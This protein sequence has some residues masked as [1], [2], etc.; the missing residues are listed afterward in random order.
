MLNEGRPI[1]KKLI[2]PNVFLRLKSLESKLASFEDA[3]A[4][5]AKLE[6]EIY[7]LSKGF[8]MVND[9]IILGDDEKE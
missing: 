7:K 4:R 1:T 3:L 5:L 2:K 8:D 9:R 6:E